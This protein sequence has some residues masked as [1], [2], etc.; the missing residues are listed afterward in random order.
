M[1]VV[2]VHI[3]IPDHESALTRLL[4]KA[5]S[6]L[7]TEVIEFHKLSGDISSRSDENDDDTDG[8]RLLRGDFLEPFLSKSRRTSLCALS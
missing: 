2:L 5:T 4:S 1:A 8:T 6:M 7:V 3:S